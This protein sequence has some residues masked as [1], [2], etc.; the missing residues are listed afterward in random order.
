MQ[1]KQY[2][3]M[4]VII[5]DSCNSSISYNKRITISLKNNQIDKRQSVLTAL[6]MM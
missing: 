4:Y 2:C 6:G 3:N 5:S 1:N